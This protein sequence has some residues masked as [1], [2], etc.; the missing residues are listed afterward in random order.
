MDGLVHSSAHHRRK[1][2]PSMM[3]DLPHRAQP[4]MMVDGWQEKKVPNAGTDE[5]K[6]V[7]FGQDHQF[8]STA[9]N[10]PYIVTTLIVIYLHISSFVHVKL[11]SASLKR[12]TAQIRCTS[13]LVLPGRLRVV[14]L[15]AINP[16]FRNTVPSS[17][18]FPHFHHRIMYVLY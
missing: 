17:A 14:G 11:I 9:S 7:I 2:N 3:P 6:Q 15:W 12:L 16:C 8:W 10:P 1:K 18:H 4:R 13:I 5:T